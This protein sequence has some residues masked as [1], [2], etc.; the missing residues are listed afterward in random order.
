[1]HNKP[2]FGNTIRHVVRSGEVVNRHYSV[3]FRDGPEFWQNTV[4]R[5]ENK[6]PN[7]DFNFTVYGCSDGSEPFTFIMA[8]LKWTK[9]LAEK[10][11]FIKALDIEPSIVRQAKTGICN[12]HDDDLEFIQRT[13]L[14][15][16]KNDYFDKVE[17]TDSYFDIG[18]KFRK[19]V[20]SKI[21]FGVADIREHVKTLDA[22]EHNAV[23]CRNLW[24]YMPLKDRGPL[25][26]NLHDKTKNGGFILIG[27]Y[28]IRHG[29][30]E[31]LERH[32][33]LKDKSNDYTWYAK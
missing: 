16:N 24:N 2:Y 15:D 11:K 21:R 1:M 8:L 20:M 13:I 12:I 14:K 3:I 29:I 4:Q 7:G 28:D 17:R 5:L 23:S 27:D 30:P 18:L 25:A 32:R 6:Y 33:F 10:L 9:N 26:E 31:I 19:N 22:E